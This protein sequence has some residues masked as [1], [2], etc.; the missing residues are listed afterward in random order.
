MDK[1]DHELG[2]FD[3]KLSGDEIGCFRALGPGQLQSEQPECSS[4]GEWLADTEWKFSFHAY[5][6]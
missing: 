2:I 4:K 1:S 5:P 3:S 6:I